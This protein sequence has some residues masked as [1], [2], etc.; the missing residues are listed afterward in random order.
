MD[1]LIEILNE[2]G[3]FSGKS[4]LKSEAHKK[5]VYH[6][7][8]HIWICNTNNQVLIQK[9]V[10]SKDSFPD[11]WDIS[12]AGHIS[13]GETPLKSALREIEEEIGLELQAEILQAIGTYKKEVVHSKHFI[14]RELHHIF[15]CK[16][17]FHLEDLSAQASE[18]S[19]LKL[20][21]LDMFLEITGS[22]EFVPHG[23]DY[24]QL[25]Y[26]ALQKFSSSSPLLKPPQ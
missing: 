22:K 4:I 12:V 18:V 24:F 8:A 5:G 25:I 2:D 9:R 3:S 23:S 7:S 16:I 19:A 1:E 14:D 6:A 10:A 15:V 11:L 17:P 20:I 13:Y 21:P 26:K